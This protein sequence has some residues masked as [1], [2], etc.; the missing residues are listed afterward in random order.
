MKSASSKDAR[1]NIGENS[2]IAIR[3]NNNRTLFSFLLRRESRRRKRKNAH[4][5]Q[6]KSLSRQGKL[7]FLFKPR[8]SAKL[9]RRGT[10][11]LLIL[12]S[13]LLLYLARCL[14]AEKTASKRGG[15]AVKLPTKN[16]NTPFSLPA[17]FHRA[18][19]T[20]FL[21]SEFSLLEPP[22]LSSAKKISLQSV[23][24]AEASRC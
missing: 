13:L 3:A 8:L 9:P 10:A 21:S 7:R 20:S 6:R 12:L 16:K 17:F 2:K 11:Y 19:L 22:L 23:I 18:S 15:N 4:L 5:G 1:S 14:T 24:D